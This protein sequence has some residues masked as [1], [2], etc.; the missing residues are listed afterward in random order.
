MS[1]TG[2][3]MDIPILYDK[4]A[5]IIIK[6]KMRPPAHLNSEKIKE[7]DCA[8]IVSVSV[9]DLGS[10]GLLYKLLKTHYEL[11]KT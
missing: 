9:M 8:E 6:R 4:C 11:A 3:K 1:R 10:Y 2:N 5:S 7:Q